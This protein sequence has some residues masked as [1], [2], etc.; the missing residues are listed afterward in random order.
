V[1]LDMQEPDAAKLAKVIFEALKDDFAK[2][3]IVEVRVLDRVEYDDD[4]ALKIE[5]IFDGA[6]KDLDPRKV[7]GAV[8][9]LRPK[10][11]AVG[12]DSFPLLYFVYKG[13]RE[14]A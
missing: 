4:D 9:Q 3:H 5:V 11:H 2:A 13:D 7:A 10:L 1:V 8:R 6:Q 14:A 12:E